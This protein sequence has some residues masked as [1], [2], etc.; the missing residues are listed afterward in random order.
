MFISWYGKLRE[1]EL[2]ATRTLSEEAKARHHAMAELYA[3]RAQ[4]LQR[5]G[6]TDA[7]PDS[8]D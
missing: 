6:E 5:H 2:S 8:D 1:K 7:S 3:R 4:Q